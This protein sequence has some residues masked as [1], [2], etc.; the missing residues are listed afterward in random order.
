ME[1]L[2][3]DRNELAGAFGDF[4]TF[5]PLVTA[6]IILNDLDPKG[7]FL[8]FGLLYVYSGFTFR[9]PIPIQPMKAIAVIMITKT[10]PLSQLVGAGLVVG[11]FFVLLAFT[12]TINLIRRVTPKSVIRGVQFGLGLNLIL[13]ALK[14]MLQEYLIGWILSLIG[15]AIALIFFNSKRFPP[16]LLLLPIGIAFS[17]YDGFPLGIFADDINIGFPRVLLPTTVDIVQGAFALAI[18]Q[19]PLTIGNAILATSLLS[20][21]YF[22]ERNRV[23]VKHLSLSHGLMN[24]FSMLMGGIP[25]CHGAG[26]LAG[27]Y[28]FGARTG[29]ALI[30]IGA[31]L[32]FLSIFYGNAISQILALFPFSILGVLLFFSGLELT[33]TI[34]DVVSEKSELLITLFV[35]IVSVTFRYGYV[36][37]LVGGVV[38]YYAI[39][40]FFLEKS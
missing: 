38:L 19:I 9:V 36:I 37:G 18:P 28:R 40:K 3:F 20:K 1:Y 16:A 26:G 21:D 11:G 2:K 35:A 10:L 7:V 15:V 39:K 5:V 17:I 22:K 27:H 30:I 6:M 31:I 34:K 8:T 4:G 24:L 33:I 32:T 12:N 29:G 23:S 25:V 13:V 14:F